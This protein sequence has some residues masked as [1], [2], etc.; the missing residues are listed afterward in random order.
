MFSLSASP[1]CLTALISQKT[2]LKNQLT[3]KELGPEGLTQTRAENLL[4]SCIYP[5][6]F[7]FSPGFIHPKGLIWVPEK[8]ESE[9]EINSL[10]GIIYLA[11][12]EEGTEAVQFLPAQSIQ[13]HWG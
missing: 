1:G 10:I 13:S 11:R 8:I 9:I 12:K 3:L 5:S 4:G 2:N 6:V 7:P